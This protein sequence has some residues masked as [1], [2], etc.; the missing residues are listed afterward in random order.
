MDKVLETIDRDRER[1]VEILREFLRIP[2][3]STTPE[4]AGDVRRAAEYLAEAG[5]VA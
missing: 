5:S 4:T 1:S 3:V 2:S